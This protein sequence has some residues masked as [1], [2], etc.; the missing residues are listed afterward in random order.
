[1]QCYYYRLTRGGSFSRKMALSWYYCTLGVPS[2]VPSDFGVF[3]TCSGVED[4]LFETLLLLFPC[5][6]NFVLQVLLVG[7]EGVHGV[8]V[9]MKSSFS[10]QE[11]LKYV[12]LIKQ[13]AGLLLRLLDWQ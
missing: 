5:F 11:Q 3:H 12:T 4:V 13:V 7:Q 8:K 2:Q 10:K 9:R 6:F 1:M